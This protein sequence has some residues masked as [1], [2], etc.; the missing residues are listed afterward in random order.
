M[1][2]RVNGMLQLRGDEYERDQQGRDEETQRDQE[3]K[4]IKEIK[5]TKETQKR[6]K[7]RAET[8]VV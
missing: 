6:T 2:R 4:E 1:V 3:T 8:Q 7:K 5:E